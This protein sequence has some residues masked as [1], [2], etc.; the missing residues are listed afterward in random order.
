MPLIAHS[1][2]PSFQRLKDQGETILS[3]DR[4]QHQVIRELHIGLLNM[5]PDAA[6]EATE[7]QF[8]RLIG[9]S[10]EIAQF[11][12]HPFSLSSVERG[13]KASEHLRKHYK[14]FD[15]IKTIGLDALIITGANVS[16]PDLQLA[17]FY[18]QL[19]EVV[20]WSY[21]N[22]TS[23]L[24]SCL[25]THAVLEF[26]YGQTRQPIGDKCWGVFPHHLVDRQHPL[27]SGVNTRF[28]IPHSRFNE[29]SEVQ[30]EKAG[31]KILAKSDEGVHLAVSPDL[32]RLVFFQGHP[33]YD[34]VS[35]LKEYKREVMLY[36]GGERDNYPPMPDNYLSAQNQAILNEYQTKLASGEMTIKDF[37]ESLI[38]ETLDNTWHDSTTAIINNWIG[39]VYQV[40][41]EDIDKPF[42]DG[43]NPQ[44]PLNLK[45]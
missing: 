16:H 34:T 11:Y 13:E 31:V 25:A 44:D 10:N 43:I 8:F 1:D 12:V 27:V 21:E 9:H 26:R 42:M 41:H 37:P 40:T 29:V 39:C 45:G 17:P 6:L 23:T 15:E 2:L 20:D 32:F 3:K 28:D 33:E 18:E 30:F 22:V 19:K 4:A 24:C 7:R 36:L 5:M 35:L 38:A 14:T